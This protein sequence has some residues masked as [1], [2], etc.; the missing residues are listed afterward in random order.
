M[1][2]CTEKYIHNNVFCYD[3]KSAGPTILKYLTDIDLLDKEKNIRNIEYGK[4]MRDNKDL[5]IISRIMFSISKIICKEFDG[6]IYTPDSVI[7][8]R[9]ITDIELIKQLNVVYKREWFANLLI[10]SKQRDS[11]I[12]LTDDGVI[13]KGR[14]KKYLTEKLIQK[15]ITLTLEDPNWLLRFKQWF[16]SLENNLYFLTSENKLYT[17]DGEI[18]VENMQLLQS[19]KINK[20]VYWRSLIAFIYSIGLENN[21]F[22]KGAKHGIK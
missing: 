22:V 4:L 6:I 1:N 13:I 9:I 18:V 5:K 10:I 2:I 12:A 17:N 11:Y 7:T 21:F 3:I 15:L 20:Y 8:H 14:L 16:K 19:Y